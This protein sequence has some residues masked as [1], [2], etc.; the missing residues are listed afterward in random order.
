VRPFRRLG[1]FERLSKLTIAVQIVFADSLDFCATLSQSRTALADEN[2][3]L[4]SNRPCSKNV[5]RR[6]QGPQPRIASSWLSWL[7]SSTGVA[8]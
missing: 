5:R 2:L 3:F 8:H 6:P 7:I 1:V 4:R